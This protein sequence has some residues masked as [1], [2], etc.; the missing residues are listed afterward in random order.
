M[1]KINKRNLIT[2]IVIILCVHIIFAPLIIDKAR[3]YELQNQTMDLLG[4][5][6][7]NQDIELMDELFDPDCEFV[8]IDYTES[9]YSSE[10]ENIGEIWDTSDFEITNYY[11][12]SIHPSQNIIFNYANFLFSVMIKDANGNRYKQSAFLQ[13]HRNDRFSCSITSINWYLS[14]NPK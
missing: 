3:W 6:L 13:I 11:Y 5:A 4:E 14:D 12:V 1:K 7:I 9:T 8:K 2:G 10:R